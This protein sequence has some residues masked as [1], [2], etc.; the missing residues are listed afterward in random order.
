M[1][2]CTQRKIAYENIQRDVQGFR[3]CALFIQRDGWMN[4]L[5][6]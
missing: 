2:L 1:V 5:N 6:S 4:A 3:M